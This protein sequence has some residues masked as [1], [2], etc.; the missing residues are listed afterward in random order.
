MSA[1]KNVSITIWPQ[2]CARIVAQQAGPKL[3]GGRRQRHGRARVSAAGGFDAVHRKG[4][5]RVDCQLRKV[6]GRGCHVEFK[7][8]SRKWEG[9]ARWG[10][11]SHA[12]FSGKRFSNIRQSPPICEASVCPAESAGNALAALARAN[13]ANTRVPASTKGGLPSISST[14]STILPSN[15]KPLMTINRPIMSIVAL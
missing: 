1:G 15:E 2:R 13:I 5:N 6:F 14:T 11:F 10:R 12:G 9:S 3:V 4:A 7:E 8:N